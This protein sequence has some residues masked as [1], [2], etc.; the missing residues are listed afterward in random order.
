MGQAEPIGDLLDA[1]GVRHSPEEGELVEGA[2][3]LLKTVGADGRVGLRVA[4]SDGISWIER[5]G[6][7]RVGMVVDESDLSGDGED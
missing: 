7:L 4:Y 2:V 5:I 3:V 1:L 6:M